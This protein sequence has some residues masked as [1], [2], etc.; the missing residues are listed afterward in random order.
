MQRLR[1]VVAYIFGKLLGHAG[2]DVNAAACHFKN[3]GEQHFRRAAF[4]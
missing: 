4:V 1:I 2:G 3:R